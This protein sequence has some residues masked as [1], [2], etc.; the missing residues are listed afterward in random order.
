MRYYY[1]VLRDNEK[2]GWRIRRHQGDFPLFEVM[3]ENPKQILM[4][5][6]EI[7]EKEALKCMDEYSVRGWGTE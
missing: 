4:F 7:P 2:L 5:W 6:K 1:F 3:T